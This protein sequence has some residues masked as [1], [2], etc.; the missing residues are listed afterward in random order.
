[1]CEILWQ[2]WTYIG[3]WVNICCH[4]LLKIDLNPA[5]ISVPH[6]KINWCLT[7][8]FWE[9]SESINWCRLFFVTFNL[10]LFDIFW[11]I[12]R[13]LQLLEVWQRLFCW[14]HLKIFKNLWFC[15]NS[16]F[17]TDN[18]KMDSI[19]YQTKS[20]WKIHAPRTF[21]IPSFEDTSYKNLDR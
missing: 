13:V 19:L 14:K 7:Q 12:F 20:K 5:Y 10:Y 8:A 15:A 6:E 2:N 16:I 18:I 11:E 17:L 9:I 4:T 1:M 21:Y 3:F